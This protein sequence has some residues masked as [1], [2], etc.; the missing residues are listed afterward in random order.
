MGEIALSLGDLRQGGADFERVRQIS[1]ALND[2]NGIQYAEAW[3]EKL[4]EDGK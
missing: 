2:R 1:L 3:L 4:S